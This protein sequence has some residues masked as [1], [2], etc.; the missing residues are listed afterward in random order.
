[1][2]TPDEAIKALGLSAIAKPRNAK[3]LA[4]SH[5]KVIVLLK[6][7]V[8]QAVL[9]GSTNF[10]EG[11]VYGHSNVVHICEDPGI[12]RE[13]LWLWNELAKNDDKV[14]T[15]PIL[16]ASWP[17]FCSSPLAAAKPKPISASPPSPSRTGG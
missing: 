1:M 8:A 12:A 10:S 17:T 6:N 9:T 16:T 15:A 13:Y 11:G 3:G 5:N 14:D 2:T 7:G 4:L